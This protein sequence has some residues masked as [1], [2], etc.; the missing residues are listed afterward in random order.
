[1]EA[2][3]K[4]LETIVAEGGKALI[5]SQFSQML[6][7]MKKEADA[8]GWPYCYLDGQT[9]ER[10]KEVDKFQNAA[11]PMLFFISLKAGGVGLN[12]TAADSVILYD[13][14]WNEA[15]EE[16]AINRAHRMGREKV[17]VAK[18]FI[19]RESIEEKIMKLKESKKKV[20]EQLFEESSSATS[21]SAQDLYELL[22]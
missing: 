4:D 1:M 12:L 21:F 11:G 17:V 20:I 3:Q 15:V 6:Q 19:I 16:Q 13:P 10:E 14:W 9:K 5:Y 22:S 8:N 18:R 7:L 2:L